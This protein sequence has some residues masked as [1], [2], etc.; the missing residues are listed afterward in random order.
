MKR[1]KAI[2]ILKKHKVSEVLFSEDVA[3]DVVIALAA[4]I[5]KRAELQAEADKAAKEAKADNKKLAVQLAEATGNPP[6]EEG[7]EEV[8]E[9]VKKANALL[10]AQTKEAQA[11]LVKS[12]RARLKTALDKAVDDGCIAPAEVDGFTALSE[13]VIGDVDES[14][15]LAAPEGEDKGEKVTAFEAMVRQV[16]GRTSLSALGE[17]SKEDA[18]EESPDEKRKAIIEKATKEFA[19]DPDAYIEAYGGKK[20]WINLA[21]TGEGMALET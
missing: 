19:E 3:D 8:P 11:A 7:D 14:V 2:K 12:R 1:E 13:A 20:E 21:L 16:E 18:D 9:S 5:E 6:P 10:A 15:E 17:M 4:D